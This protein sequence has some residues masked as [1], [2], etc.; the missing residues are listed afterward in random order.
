MCCVPTT[1]EKLIYIFKLHGKI[2]TNSLELKCINKTI[3]TFAAGYGER[4]QRPVIPGSPEGDAGR[5]VKR[6]TTAGRSR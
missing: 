3:K 5:R 1:C 2:N 6:Q 4:T